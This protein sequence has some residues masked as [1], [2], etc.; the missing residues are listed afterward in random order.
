MAVTATT[1][2]PVIRDFDSINKKML[3]AAVQD[4]LNFNP[5][6]TFFWSFNDIAVAQRQL[7]SLQTEAV[8]EFF[9]N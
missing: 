1:P 8:P 3:K 7:K 5:S 9:R 6:A 2:L 4:W